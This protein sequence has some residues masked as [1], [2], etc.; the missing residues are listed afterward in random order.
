MVKPLVSIYIT[1]CNRFDLLPRAIDS[2]LAQDYRPL[3][4]IV[5]D[6]ASIDSTLDVLQSYKNK[7][8]G[9]HDLTFSFMV[10]S[11]NE[12]ACAA[13]NYAIENAKGEYITGLDDDDEFL[14]DRIS[15]FLKSWNDKCSALCSSLEVDDGDDKISYLNKDIGEINMNKLLN[16]N[17]VGSQV[18]T[19]TSRLKSIGGFDV[20]FPA[21][22]DYECW[23]RLVYKCGPILKL[24]RPSYRVHRAHD[25]PRIT[26]DEKTLKAIKLVLQKH[27]SKFNGRQKRLLKYK[28]LIARKQPY[29]NIQCWLPA[30][31][32][33]TAPRILSRWIK[34]NLR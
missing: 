11:A 6:D 30:I 5:V 22:Q 27:D 28:E 13:R 16:R 26:S 1:T 29:N 32:F 18:F 8:A 33:R 17:S 21:W 20:G 23:I 7:L 2:V 25:K 34:T 15:S 3:E 10:K 24:E 9:L 19:K 12:G 14:P 4:I 31:T